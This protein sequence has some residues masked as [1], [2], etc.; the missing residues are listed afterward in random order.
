M[1]RPGRDR[2][3][4]LVE[5]DETF[6]GGPRPGKPG[7]GASGKVLVLIAV[8][9]REGT[10]QKGIGRIRLRIIPDASGS[11]LEDAVETMVEPGSTIRTDGW[12]GYNGLQGKGFSHIVVKHQEN[13]PGHDPT[14]LVHRIASLLKRWLLGTHQGGAQSSHLHYYLD[15]FTF[16]FNR[17]RARSRGKLFYELIRQSL[18]VDPAP[19]ETLKACAH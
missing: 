10:K 17:R 18:L 8:E 12:N 15:E 9:D 6:V 4:G 2:L 16:R 13:E 5:V 14:P 7:R 11:T 19:V 3:R 1:V